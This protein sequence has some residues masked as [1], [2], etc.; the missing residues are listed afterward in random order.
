MVRNEQ[1]LQVE[2]SLT[3][4]IHSVQLLAVLRTEKE[5]SLSREE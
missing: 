2:S 3:M 4:W 1:E 5:M